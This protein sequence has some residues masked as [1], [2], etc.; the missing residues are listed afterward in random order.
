MGRVRRRLLLLL[1]LL[2]VALAGRAVTAPAQVPIPTPTITPAPTLTPTPTPTPTPAPTDTPVPPPLPPALAPGPPQSAV[3]VPELASDAFASPRMLLRW[4]GLGADDGRAA[5]FLVDVRRQGL[6]AAADWRALVA[7]SPARAATFTGAPGEAYVVRVRSRAAGSDDYGPAALSSVLVP[8]DERDRRVKL[9]RGWTKHRRA[10]AWD[11]TTAVASSS[12]ATAKLRFSKRRVRVIVRRTPSS[13]RLA[14]VL[15]GH[16]SVVRLA[17]PA[18]QRQVA[19]DS[20]RLRAGA[21]R[22]TLKPAGG[23]VE[24]DA[25]AP[26]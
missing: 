9:S 21:H 5:G 16:R 13:G 15:D 2:T 22:L 4:G 25:I 8:L 18:G 26:G 17:G 7:G 3:L 24:I 19:F 6:H 12:K 11:G 20:G 1:G 23:S 14:V 10:G